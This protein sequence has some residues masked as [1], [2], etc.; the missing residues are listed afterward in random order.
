MHLRAGRSL[1]FFY[2]PGS[3]LNKILQPLPGFVLLSV[4]FLLDL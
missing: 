1:P 2:I 3:W 4:L